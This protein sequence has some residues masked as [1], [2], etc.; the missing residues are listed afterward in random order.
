M[1][2]A[3]VLRGEAEAPYSLNVFG[4]GIAGIMLPAVSRILESE[5]FHALVPAGF[6]QYGSGG[7]AGIGGVAVYN[8]G[9]W[10]AAEGFEAVAVNQQEIGFYRQRFDRALHSCNAGIQ[11][12]KS[13]YLLCLNC[14][15]RPCYGF[16]FDNRAEGFA[17]FAGHLLGVV[18]QRVEE[19]CRKNNCRGVHRACEGAAPGLVAPGFEAAGFHTTQQ[20]DFLRHICK[21]KQKAGLFLVGIYFM[22]KIVDYLGKGFQARINGV[23]P[24]GKHINPVSQTILG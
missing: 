5:L 21:G 10:D 9:V 17:G 11:D 18:E 12:I 24:V 4:G 20:V 22:Q 23:D 7:D 16:P 15:Y 2:A 6:G 19:I 3:T 8:S 1:E 14:R 13:V